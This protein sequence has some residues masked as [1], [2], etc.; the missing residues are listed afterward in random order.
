M[1]ILVYILSA[2]AFLGEY[3]S[4]ESCKNAIREIYT[5]QTNPPNQRLPELNESINLRISMQKS[6]VCLPKKKD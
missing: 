5:V 4:L 3:S 2:P 1:Y 6:Y